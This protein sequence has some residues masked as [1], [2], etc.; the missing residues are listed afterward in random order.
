MRD[1][2]E[3]VLVAIL[4]TASLVLMVYLPTTEWW[5]VSIAMSFY[6]G[7][8]ILSG[9]S[10]WYEIAVSSYYYLLVFFYRIR[11]HNPPVTKQELYQ[12][13]R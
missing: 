13:L 1:K 7:Y 2:P 12:L 10:C 5:V 11:K 6:G 9:R 8:L 3:D 4:S